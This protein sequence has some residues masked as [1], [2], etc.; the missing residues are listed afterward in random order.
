MDRIDNE[1]YFSS[2]FSCPDLDIFISELRT[3]D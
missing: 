2:T 1:E 3:A